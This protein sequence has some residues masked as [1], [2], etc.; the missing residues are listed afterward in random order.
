MKMKNLLLTAAAT[1]GMTALS[2]AQNVPNY[3]PTNGLVGWWPFN[4][5][6]NDESGNGNNGIINGTILTADRIGN[7]ASA[8]DFNSGNSI[9]LPNGSNIQG[10]NPRTISFWMKPEITNTATYTIYKGGTNGN[11]NDFTIWLRKNIGNTYQLYIRRFVD[12]VV[13]DSIPIDLNWGH[14]SIVYDGTV[15]SNIKFFMN[16]IE[17]TGRA[18]AGSG[19]NFNTA[20]TQPEF[21]HNI[22]Q[23]GVHR[24]FDGILDDIAIWNRAL[25]QQE[26]TD[27]YNSVNCDN[28]TTITPATSILSTGSTAIFTASSSDSNPSYEWQSDFG[29]GFQTLNN[30]GNYSGTNTATL[31]ITNAQLSEHNQPIRV[32]STSG[33]CIDTSNVAII[34]ITDTCINTIT[35]TTFITV[36]DTLVI[37][38]TITSLNPP[39]NANTIKVFPNPTNDHITIDYGNFSLMNGYQLKIEN[40]L[41]QQVFQ[42]NIT[43]QSDYLNLTTWGG[44]GLYFVHIIDPQGNTIDIR[45]I[46][47]Q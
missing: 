45:K 10:N 15:N 2:M 27:L 29:Q 22:D 47:L 3:V 17:H 24:Y 20:S 16:G 14:Y 37:N 7:Q 34:S 35:D 6:A 39:N 42:T 40:S 9:V 25:T 1:F 38:T 21:G 33:N 8:Y 41:G 19:L 44:N 4:G 28:N 32:I 5:N 36:T 43:Q 18:S 30:F 31:N 26:I 11:G 13:T 12:D 46:V 23:L